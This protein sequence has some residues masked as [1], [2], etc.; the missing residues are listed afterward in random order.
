MVMTSGSSPEDCWGKITR[1]PNWS[2]TCGVDQGGWKEEGKGRREGQG[3]GER[4]EGNGMI[5]GR[6]TADQSNKGLCLKA[7]TI[8]QR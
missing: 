7:L 1:A 4:M 6:S 2:R 3:E 5:N 8:A